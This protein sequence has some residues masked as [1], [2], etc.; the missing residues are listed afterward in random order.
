MSSTELVPLYTSS[1]S[2]S[3]RDISRGSTPLKTETPHHGR[4]YSIESNTSLYSPLDPSPGPSRSASEHSP[5]LHLDQ[6]FTRIS[7]K[8]ASRSSSRSPEASTSPH[9]D[10]ILTNGTHAH[11]SRPLPHMNGNNGT[12]VPLKPPSVKKSLPDLRPSRLHLP[13]GSHRAAA[14]S[15]D[16]LPRSV[17]QYTEQVSSLLTA[18]PVRIIIIPST[19]LRT[20]PYQLLRYP[21]T[22]LFRPW[23]PN[24]IHTFDDY[25]PFLRRRSRKRS[26]HRSLQSWTRLEGYCSRSLRSTRR[27]SIIRCTPSTSDY[28]P[29][30]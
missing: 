27:C 16:H 28:P 22:D 26:R 10:S 6:F 21:W 13:N 29:F 15:A 18:L 5:R 23:T 24:A 30:C 2:N 20:S 4:S 1:F 11:P 7:D 17:S 14:A 9:E 12:R 3:S 8:N 19:R 25:P